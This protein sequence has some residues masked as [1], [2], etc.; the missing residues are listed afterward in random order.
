M[1]IYLSI[2]FIFICI[3]YNRKGIPIFLYHQVN[4]SSKVTPE[5]FERHLQVLK[6]KKMETITISQMLDKEKLKNSV[7]ITLDDGY[8]DN[9]KYVFP[10]LKKYNMKATIFLNTAF[11]GEERKSDV[12][13]KNNEEANLVSAKRYLDEG[14]EI[15]EQYMTWNEIKEMHESGLV[16]FQ[17]HSHGHR[18]IFKNNTILGFFEEKE[19]IDSSDI[20]LYGI[21]KGGYPKFG[22]RGEYSIRGIDVDKKL[23]S[24]FQKYY[25]ENLEKL[26][27]SKRIKEGQNYIDKELKKYIKEVTLEEFEQRIMNDFNKNKSMIE[28]KLGN[29]VLFFCWPWGHRGPEAMAVLKKNGVKGFVSTKKGTNSYRGDLDFIKR[30]E[31]REFTEKK[32]RINLFLGR[33]LILGKIYQLLS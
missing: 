16:D 8:Y 13:I 20:Y 12:E 19:K 1:I 24:E 29:E 4:P 14:T 23:F 2:F 32:Y 6:E 15:S 9:Y 5:L 31:L 25:Y 18:A 27:L 33:N 3:Y 30:I 10:L 22:K 26:D 21:P 17:A 11:L 7:L 28:T